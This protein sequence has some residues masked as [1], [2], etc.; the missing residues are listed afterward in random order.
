MHKTLKAEKQMQPLKPINIDEYQ[1]IDSLSTNTLFLI[2]IMRMRELNEV[3]GYRNGDKI[4][5]QFSILFKERII[6]EIEKLLNEFNEKKI[7]IEFHNSYVDIFSLKI[8]TSL[9]ERVILHIKKLILKNVLDHKFDIDNY[10]IKINIDVTIGCAKGSDENLMINTEKALYNAKENYENYT[11]F[12]RSL[13]SDTLINKNLIE[14]MRY[15]IEEKKVEPY[16]QEIIDTQSSATYKYEALMR[17]V[18]KEGCVLSPG[19]FMDKS[20]KYRLYPQLMLVMIEKV[21]ESIKEHGINASINLDYYSFTN[22]ALKSFII[23]S[24]RQNGN[25]KYLT[26]EILESEKIHDFDMVNDFIKELRKHDVS[27][28]IDD[29]GTG[30][31]NYEHILQLDI[32]YIKL[33]G[34]LVKRVNED[35]YY[36]LIKSIVGF[37]KKQ[38]IKVVAEFVSNLSILRYAKTLNIDYC[39]G[40]YISKPKSIEEINGENYER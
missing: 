26:V 37:C 29:F 34:S 28:A 36:E 22:T 8:Y 7:Y 16:F 33:D 30:F 40:Y 17:L 39:Q 12:D 3:Y 14:T 1:P 19:A 6:P 20:K 23:E 4:L 15:N 31:S 18:D 9:D 35:I 21:F 32:D 27:I 11:F 10:G 13:S 38:D 25:G 2:D 24:L 5:K